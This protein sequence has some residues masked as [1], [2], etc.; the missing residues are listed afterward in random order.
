MSSSRISSVRARSLGIPFSGKPGTNNSITDVPGVE[1][2][3]V[4][5]ILGDDIRTGVTA[6]LPRGKKDVGIP[7]AA[8]IFS[9]NGN[10]EMTGSHWIEES[11]SISTPI[12]ITN[13]HAVGPIHQGV[14]EWVIEEFPYLAAQWLLPVVAETWDGYLNAINRIVITTEDAKRAIESAKS[15]LIEEGSVGGGTG[16]NCY[17]YKGGSGTS[18]RLVTYGTKTYTV[19]V[20]VQANF[21]SREELIIR[22]VTMDD[23]L[24][25]NAIGKTDWQISDLEVPPGAG[26][27]NAIVATDAPLLPNQC[28]ALARRLPLGIARTGT[29]GS[30]FSGDIFLAFS[31]ANRGSLTSKFALRNPTEKNYETL[32]FIP[33][34][35]IDDFY[36]ATVEAVEEAVI[37]ALV[38]NS[39][40]EG[41]DGHVS[42]ALPHSLIKDK[43]EI[44]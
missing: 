15:G 23:H 36:S 28:K 18:S 3:Y 41:R 20:F 31:T 21:G 8:A 43:L 11:G 6:V 4:T 2:G 32:S 29:S 12:M 33:W 17:Q 13:T 10:G 42:Y 22:G 1:V 9:M 44:I 37:N 25:P 34:G 5:R 38:S 26:S 16:M 24:T 7:C 39:D 14:I 30:H 27:V 40:M 35:S 19:G